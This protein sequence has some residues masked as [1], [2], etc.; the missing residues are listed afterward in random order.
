[1]VTQNEPN[2]CPWPRHILPYTVLDDRTQS[3]GRNNAELRL[4]STFLAHNSYSGIASLYQLRLL[5]Q[6]PTTATTATNKHHGYQLPL[7]VSSKPYVPFPCI[8]SSRE[9]E[10]ER[11]APLILIPSERSGSP[12]AGED[13]ELERCRLCD[14][15]SGVDLAFDRDVFRPP[16]AGETRR[17][18]PMRNNNDGVSSSI[19]VFTRFTVVES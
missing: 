17:G 12:V 2:K 10:C 5:Y 13:C 18:C 14:W 7:S 8:L 16:A 3:L 9:C 1:M 11:A 6:V 15:T 19:P 4:K